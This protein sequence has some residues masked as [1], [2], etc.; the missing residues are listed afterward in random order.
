MMIDTLSTPWDFH[1]N[2]TKVV[3]PDGRYRLVYSDLTEIAMGAP[4]S[5]VCALE[6]PD[7]ASTKV[8]D[9]C[10]GP[11]VWEAGSALVAI[12]IWSKDFGSGQKLG[13]VDLV[14]KEFTIYSRPFRVL[15]LREF[16]GNIVSGFD[17]PIH[18]TTTVTFDMQKEYVR[19][20][21][22]LKLP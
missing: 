10:G 18:R 16:R 5:G 6:T 19:K 13:I 21:V 20:V 8:H 2:D 7:H 4:L 3:S 14:K 1:N 15:D 17:S 22:K 12:P 11:P 9:R